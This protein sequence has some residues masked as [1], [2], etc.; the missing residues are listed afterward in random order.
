M[1]TKLIKIQYNKE[2]FVHAIIDPAGLSGFYIQILANLLVFAK[3]TVT[4]HFPALC[5]AKYFPGFPAKFAGFI[6]RLFMFSGSVLPC[7]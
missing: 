2:H 1:H 4:F 5:R 3:S 6:C 7:K